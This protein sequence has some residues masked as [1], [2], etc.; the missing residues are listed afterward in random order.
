MRVFSY[1]LAYDSGYAP[2]P[3]HGICTLA[4][5]KPVIRRH[6][7]SGDII[8]G[9]TSKARGNRLVY[10]MRVAERLSFEQYWHDQR[11]RA[12][13]PRMS[14][15]R[16]VEKAGDN[17]YE[18]IG[19]GRFRQRPSRHSH[20]DGTEDRQVMS[21][22]LGA[23]RGNSVLMGTDFAYFGVEALPLP[24]ELSFL[25]VRRG[26]RST[27]TEKQIRLVRKLVDGLPRGVHASPHLWPDEDRTWLQKANARRSRSTD[28]AQRGAR[29]RVG[30]AGGCS[31]TGRSL[32]RPQRRC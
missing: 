25:A 30:S 14:S 17:H 2:N 32:A 11:F 31:R 5:C 28:G 9:L 8:I 24:G 7:Q 29:C 15:A 3:F 22:D 1:I 16:A 27:F 18:P 12:K 6:A 19:N 20:D 26:H 21:H 4:C 10:G 23:D 13:R